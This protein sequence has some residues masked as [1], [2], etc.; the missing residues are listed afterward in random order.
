MYLFLL[1][2]LKT[3]ESAI[4]K[5]TE[6]VSQIAPPKR[7]PFGP[8]RRLKTLATLQVGATITCAIAPTSKS[9]VLRALS[10][11]LIKIER[12]AMLTEYLAAP[13]SRRLFV[14]DQH[15]GRRFLVDS[16]AKISLLPG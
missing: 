13:H 5:L 9:A 6:Q 7:A 8:I 3:I 14:T 15:T 16:G 11:P 1:E 4:L 2:L 10:C 12:A